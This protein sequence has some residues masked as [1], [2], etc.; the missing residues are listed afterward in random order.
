MPDARTRLAE[1]SALART[2]AD[3]ADQLAAQ[4]AATRAEAD[5][6]A[7]EAASLDQPATAET[8]EASRA[9]ARMIAEITD[10]LRH[11]QTAADS[12]EDPIPVGVRDRARD[13]LVGH[14]DPVAADWLLTHDRLYAGL[15]EVHRTAH[16]LLARTLG[17][18]GDLPGLGLADDDPAWA[19][20]DRL[21]LTAFRAAWG[22]LEYLAGLPPRLPPRGGAGR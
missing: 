9:A 17:E 16:D 18:L 22:R 13:G 7:A 3:E 4:A 12:P 5:Q 15:V 14:L 20:A 2:R 8:R 10:R 21:E 6:L 19:A 1:L 11:L